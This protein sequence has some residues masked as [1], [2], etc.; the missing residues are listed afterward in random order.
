MKSLKWDTYLII[1]L[2]Q[3]C[4]YAPHLDPMHKIEDAKEH[5]NREASKRCEF[6]GPIQYTGMGCSDVQE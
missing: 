2:V 6:L 1:P 4:E 3:E 5:G